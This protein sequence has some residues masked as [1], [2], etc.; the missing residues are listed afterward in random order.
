MPRTDRNYLMPEERA[1]AERALAEKR[2][3]EARAAYIQRVLDEPRLWFEDACRL[4]TCDQGDGKAFFDLREGSPYQIALDLFEKSEKHLLLLWP[5]GTGKTYFVLSWL[6]VRRIVKNRDINILLSGENTIAVSDR[7]MWLRTILGNCE[8]LFGKFFERG[9]KVTDDRFWVKRP[10]GPGGMPT[11]I[12]SSPE[13]AQTGRHWQLA[14]PDDV[15]GEWAYQ[16]VLRCEKG[17]KWFYSTWSQKLP[18]SRMVFTGTP[19]PGS[20]MVYREIVDGLE[21]KRVEWKEVRSG[22]WIGEGRYFTIFRCEDRD[23]K[24]MPIFRCQND[25]FL[26]EQA[27]MPKALY[28]SQYKCRFVGGEDGAVMDESMLHR[29]D[30]PASLAG[31]VTMVTDVAHSEQRRHGASKSAF[32][33]VLW[34][35]DGVPY[36]QDF[37]AGYISESIG[38]GL[39]VDMLSRAMG[40]GRP[41]TKIVMEK[42]GPGGTYWQLIAAEAALRGWNRENVENMFVRIGRPLGKDYRIQAFLVPNLHKLRWCSTVP[43]DMI[44]W[45]ETGRPRGMVVD[46]LMDF[47]PGQDKHNDIADCLTDIFAH[48][49]FGLSLCP[50]PENLTQRETRTPEEFERDFYNS[51]QGGGSVID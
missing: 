36:V 26:Q 38:P 46:D 50:R 8:A 44:R 9:I 27:R 42:T 40:R 4:S 17:I 39:V 33:V 1:A 11:V 45:D 37:M 47:T 15:V 22:M 49:D 5:R 2:E 31:I 20:R 48:D 51:I 25:T 7:L 34:G 10:S 21:K 19:W 28:L 24:G 12:C 43:Q 16:S 30:P 18:Q 35:A 23:D 6:G 41:V 13:K 3:A 32:A 29:G 14:L